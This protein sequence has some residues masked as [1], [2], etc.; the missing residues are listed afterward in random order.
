MA[1]TVRM[2]ATN[3]SR[4]AGPAVHGAIMRRGFGAD[5]HVQS[6]LIHMDAELGSFG[7]ARLLFLEIAHLDLVTQIAM[8]G[9]CAGSG[10]IEFTRELFDEMPHRDPIAWNAMIMG[11]AHL[12][13][14]REALHLFNL[15]QLEGVTVN[16]ATL[17]SVLSVCAH[18]GALDQGRWAHIYIERNRLQ[19]TVTL[20]TALIDMYSKCGHMT[21]AKEVFWGMRERNVYTWSSVMSGLAMNGA[22][23]RCLEIFSLMQEEGILP[24]EITFIYILHGCSVAGRVDKGCE[25]FDS[26]SRVYRFEPRL[27]HYGCMV[28]LYGRAGRLTEAVDFINN[29]PVKPHVGAWGDLLNA[30]RIHRNLE[31]GEFALSKIVELERGN[32]RAYVLLSNSYADTRNWDGVSNV[33]KLMKVNGVRKEPECSVIEVGGEI[34]EFLVGNK[35]HLRYGE[36]EMML[37]EMYR[38]LRLAGYVANTEQVLFDIEEEEKEDALYRHSEKVAIA[39]GLVSL[40]EGVAIRI[41][42][43]LRVCRDCHDATKMISKVFNREIVVRDR[44]RFHHFKDGE[45]FCIDYW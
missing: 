19:M 28:D 20:G 26:M 38:K 41:V 27:E 24:N 42:K 11:Y 30:C 22:G 23:E 35:T 5:A 3:S 15:M 33:R 45:C 36:I 9:A 39:F 34:H 44:N 29:M 12:G 31:L 18:L 25:H 40:D 21:R 2:C 32:D 7:P 6:G 1:L 37:G 13:K 16:E 14:S 8:V 4:G 43:N 10:D 17:V